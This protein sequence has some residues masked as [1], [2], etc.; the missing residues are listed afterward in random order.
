MI[1]QSAGFYRDSEALTS[2]SLVVGWFLSRAAEAAFQFRVETKSL[3]SDLILSRGRILL[4]KELQIS[5]KHL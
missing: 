5:S 1:Y 3:V 4:A 2:P